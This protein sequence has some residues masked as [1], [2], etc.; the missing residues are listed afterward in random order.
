MLGWLDGWIGEGKG[1]ERK[2]INTSSFLAHTRT[3]PA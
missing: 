1:E 2:E 3:H